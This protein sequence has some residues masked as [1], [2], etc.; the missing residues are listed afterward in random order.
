MRDFEVEV[1]AIINRLIN[2]DCYKGKFSAVAL[3]P[4]VFVHLGPR[5]QVELMTVFSSVSQDE[6]PSVRK[7][8]AIAMGPMINLLPHTSDT[9]LLTIFARLFKD[10]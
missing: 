9:E 4:F 5:S 1:M 8:A 10:D 6:T 3:I 2:A 7:N